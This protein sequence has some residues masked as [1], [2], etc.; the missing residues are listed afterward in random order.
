MAWASPSPLIGAGTVKA[1]KVVYGQP[2]F[3]LNPKSKTRTISHTNL[4]N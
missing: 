3:V 1:W 2:G 4:R